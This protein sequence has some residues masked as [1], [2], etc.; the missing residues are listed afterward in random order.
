MRWCKYFV[1][2]GLQQ[3]ACSDSSTDE[4]ATEATEADS[5]DSVGDATDAAET[6][7]SATDAAET[8]GAE[9]DA[10]SAQPAEEEACGGRGEALDGLEVESEQGLMLRLIAAE[11]EEQIVG[12]NAWTFEIEDDG[13]PVEGLEEV[14]AV[15]PFMPDHGHGTAVAVE[16]SEV[17]A[18]EYEL[19]PVNLRMPGYWL[20]TIEIDAATED[21]EP[22]VATFGVCVE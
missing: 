19:S 13:S 7:E 4:S 17:E 14:M 6:D 21:D 9:P 15:T 11:P 8:E 2:L 12:D 1:L 20:I 18:G 22:D 5:T 16:I 10:S 3:A